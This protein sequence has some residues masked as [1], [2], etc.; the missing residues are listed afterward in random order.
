MISIQ[1]KECRDV[2]QSVEDFQQNVCNVH[3]FSEVTLTTKFHVW[4]LKI[5]RFAVNMP[6]DLDPQL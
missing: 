4:W 2:A 6:S 1:E 5:T 3:E